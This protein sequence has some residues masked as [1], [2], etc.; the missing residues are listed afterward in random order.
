M[1]K[2]FI[3]I[4]YHFIFAG[5]K[6]E[7]CTIDINE[8]HDSKG[9]CQNGG[10]CINKIGGYTCSCF[11]NTNGKNCEFKLEDRMICEDHKNRSCSCRPGWEGVFCREDVNECYMR[12]P[13]K[14]SAVCTNLI[15]SY[16]CSCTRGFEG[17]NCELDINECATHAPC[18]NGATCK[19]FFGTYECMCPPLYEG[20]HC[21]QY[22]ACGRHASCYN[23]GVC[24]W[25]EGHYVCK[26]RR[27]FRGS[28]CQTPTMSNNCDPKAPDEDCR[29]DR[30][31]PVNVKCSHFL[32][33][34]L[35]RANLLVREIN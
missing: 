5:W 4:S 30:G 28:N 31:K 17:H 23:G 32:S 25:Q 7:N 24:I 9:L 20:A 6:G 2:V 16:K 27:E 8:C 19:N 34:F 13:C 1:K 14:N 3:V 11:N 12:R 29:I 33:D 18:L 35:S 10:K 15:G 26:C 22:V 21:Q